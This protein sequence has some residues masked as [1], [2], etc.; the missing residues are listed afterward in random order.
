MI[1]VL[2]LTKNEEKDLPGCLESVRWSDDV[3]VF[4]SMS[5]DGTVGIATGAG[6]RVCQ[7]VFDNYAAQRNAGL[8]V[9]FKY[10]WVLILDADERIPAVLAE[11]IK[12][13]VQKAAPA[14]GGLRIRRRDFLHGVWLKHAQLSPF[15]IRVVRKGAASYSREINEVLEVT[16]T[17]ENLKGYF[18]HYPFSKGYSHWLRKHNQYSTMEAERWVFEHRNAIRFSVSKALFSK[19]FSERRYHQKG[20]FYKMPGR[21][22]IKWAYMVFFRLAILDG[23]AGL[24][25]ATLQAIYE[26]FII[27]KTREILQTKAL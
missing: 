14:V 18:D 22:F 6:A 11:E 5:D 16:G 27:L 3:V 7:R 26:Y 25:Y 2:I 8:S 21:P 4:D 23:R 15:Y 12:E 9:D 1:S 24:T 13:S 20:V 10:P 19:D 17:V